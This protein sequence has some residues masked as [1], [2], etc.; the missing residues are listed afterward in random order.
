M[1]KGPSCPLI[2]RGCDAPL[3]PPLPRS[4]APCP[5]ALAHGVLRP[6]QTCD[7]LP[8]VGR[9]VEYLLNTGNL[10]SKS[11]LDLSQA[12][13]FTVGAGAPTCSTLCCVVLVVAGGCRWYRRCQRGFSRG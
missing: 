4:L 3:S 9:K 13:G 6:A 5:I 10:V 11:G 7:K 2:M 12:S 1:T 8:D